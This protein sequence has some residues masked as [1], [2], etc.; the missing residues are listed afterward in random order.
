MSIS[1]RF[2]ELRKKMGYKQTEFGKFFDLS[3]DSISAIETGRNKPT[4]SV[5]LKL[6]NDFDI[7]IEWLLAGKGSM[8]HTTKLVSGEDIIIPIPILENITSANYGKDHYNTKKSNH[9]IPITQHLIANLPREK[10]K[11]LEIQDNAMEPSLFIRDIVM[12]MEEN[13]PKTDGIY[14]INRN[15]KL[16][17]KR[18]F[19][20]TNGNILIQSDNSI[21]PTEE[22]TPAEQKNLVLVGKTLW[23][24][25]DT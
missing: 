9:I 11:A 6:K 17:A 3:Q 16:I 10:I 4:I 15:G 2:K 23:K 25:Q 1:E 13:L 7:D 12:F 24:F 21:Y 14:I 20:K 19:Y 18:I 22:L 5:L 8:F